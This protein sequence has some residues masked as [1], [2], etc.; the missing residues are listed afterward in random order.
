M[1]WQNGVLVKGESLGGTDTRTVSL[2]A[3]NGRVQVTRGREVV[4][5][6]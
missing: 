3:A 2:L 1:L 5:E 4:E 6:L